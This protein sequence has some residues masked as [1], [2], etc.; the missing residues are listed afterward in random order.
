M[1]YEIKK[2][3]DN[4]VVVNQD[5]GKMVPGGSHPSKAKASAHMRALYA[6]VPDAS[7][8]IAG[9]LDEAIKGGPGSGRH[10]YGAGSHDA[11]LKEHGFSPTHSSNPGE[12]NY[13]RFSERG[14]H[15]VTIFK[16]PAGWVHQFT[17]DNK[18]GSGPHRSA[19]GKSP[20][21]LHERLSKF[22]KDKTMKGFSGLSQQIKSRVAEIKGGP[23]SGRHPEGGSQRQGQEDRGERGGIRGQMTSKLEENNAILKAENAS[24]RA[25][26]SGKASDHEA[27]ATAHRLAMS[28]IG[29]HDEESSI[30]AN[31]HASMAD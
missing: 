15:D 13:T 18:P 14:I 22:D 12:K 16:Q 17:D 6:N 3:G 20:E 21:S 29:I 7:K 30:R 4:F 25:H 8:S 11:V 2:S 9:R 19:M 24:E 10:P 31:H 26:E 28:K 23:G 27:A 5:T 1:P